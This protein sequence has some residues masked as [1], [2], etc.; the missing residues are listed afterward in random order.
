[1]DRKQE[2]RV[3]MHASYTIPLSKT[4]LIK[5]RDD[6]E[7]REIAYKTSAT[8]DWSVTNTI[9]HPSNVRVGVVER[10]DE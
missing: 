2:W 6:D 5:A 4:V 3:E 9:L 8:G 10:E 1:M 7:A